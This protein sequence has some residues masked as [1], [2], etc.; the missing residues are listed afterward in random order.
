G[1]AVRAGQRA[2]QR[3]GFDAARRPGQAEAFA[4][5][6]ALADAGEGEAVARQLPGG[7][8]GNGR[9]AADGDAD[10]ARRGVGDAHGAAGAEGRLGAGAVVPRAQLRIELL[11]FRGVGGVGPLG[12]GGVDHLSGA[13]RAILTLVDD[14]GQ[15][16]TVAAVGA[17]L[18]ET[19]GIAAGLDAAD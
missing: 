4:D 9:R 16:V 8:P 14:A 12:A 5:G 1:A 2:G 7:I 13:A 6:G 15:A 10:D 3:R 11:V 18:V 19:P 17:G